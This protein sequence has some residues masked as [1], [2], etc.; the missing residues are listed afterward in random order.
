MFFKR[1]FAENEL[2]TSSCNSFQRNIENIVQDTLCNEKNTCLTNNFKI[3]EIKN[4]I[5]KLRSNKS[6]GPDRIPAEMLK[7]SPDTIIILLL[8]LIN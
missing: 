2:E 4:A 6:T 3:K 5:I 1:L 8:K 7:E